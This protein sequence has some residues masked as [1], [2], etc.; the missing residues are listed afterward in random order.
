MLLWDLKLTLKPWLIFEKY[1]SHC[2]NLTF[3]Q[4]N[5]QWCKGMDTLTL[6]W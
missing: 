1:I 5:W 2:Q 6:S 3:M 4:C